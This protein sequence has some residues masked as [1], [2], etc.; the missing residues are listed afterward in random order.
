MLEDGKVESQSNYYE[1]GGNPLASYEHND[2]ARKAYTAPMGDVIPVGSIVVDADYTKAFTGVAIPSGVDTSK[3]RILAFVTDSA[4]KVL[5]VQA[6]ATG[7]NK[8]FD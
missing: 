6:S 8:D 4:D 2:I 5:N 7:V 3:L 1:P